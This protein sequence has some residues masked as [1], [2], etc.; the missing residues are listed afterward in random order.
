MG[1]VSEKKL[2]EH[3]RT[4]DFAQCAIIHPPM[5]AVNNRYSLQEKIT[6]SKNKL[7]VNII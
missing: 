7:A 5:C 4:L 3:V 1:I 2:V 6:N